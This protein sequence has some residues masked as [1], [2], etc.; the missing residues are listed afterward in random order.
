MSLKMSPSRIAH[1]AVLGAIA[2]ALVGCGG[3]RQATGAAK[4]APDEFAVMTKSP[5]IIPPDFNLRPP[6]PG[7]PDRNQGTPADMARTALFGQNPQ[8][9]AAALGG[10]F[11]DGERALLARSGGS[12]ADPAI[13]EAISSDSGL[14]DQGTGFAERII[15][16]QGAAAPA[17]QPAPAAAP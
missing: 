7:A 17:A 13:R 3:F 5:L 10:S 12:V 16:P 14:T 15:N 8:A 11:S 6:I 4:L 2:F 1:A 9:A